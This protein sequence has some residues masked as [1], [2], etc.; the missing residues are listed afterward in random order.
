MAGILQP[1]PQPLFTMNQFYSN[2]PSIS[3]PSPPLQLPH[4]PGMLAA[5]PNLRG[6]HSSTQTPGMVNPLSSPLDT[7]GSPGVLQFESLFPVENQTTPEFLKFESLFPTPSPNPRNLNSTQHRF[8]PSPMPSQS[9]QQ[10]YPANPIFNPITQNPGSSPSLNQA[11]RLNHIPDFLNRNP[12]PD[13][14][15]TNQNPEPDS[16]IG[17]LARVGGNERMLKIQ[18]SVASPPERWSQ[19]MKYLWDRDGKQRVKVPAVAGREIDIRRLML[20][21]RQWGGLQEVRSRGLWLTVLEEIHGS[22]SETEAGAVKRFVVKHIAPY[23]E[24]EVLTALRIPRELLCPPPEPEVRSSSEEPASE[25][26]EPM[27][28]PSERVLRKRTNKFSVAD[29][30]AAYESSEEDE[31]DGANLQWMRR[32]R[33]TPAGVRVQERIK[34]SIIRCLR[35][36]PLETKAALSLS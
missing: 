29:I 24:R 3:P 5:F 20:G 13:M 12:G 23:G 1:L 15:V 25:S 36:R 17:C 19:A 21:V 32:W 34:V 10:S 9:S 33:M 8:T 18:C 22:L 28:P 16:V 4:I 6:G 11:P 26:E 31:S 14:F 27:P 30:F 7:R 35:I 2:I